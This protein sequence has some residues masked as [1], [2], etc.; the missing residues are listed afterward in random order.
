MA[1]PNEYREQAKRCLELAA[2][3]NDAWL[4]NNLIE[5]AQGWERLASVLE[6]DTTLISNPDRLHK[7]AG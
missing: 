6:A 5:A 4:K 1:D 7:R 2:D 3:T